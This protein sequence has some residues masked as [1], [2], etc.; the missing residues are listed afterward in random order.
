MVIPRVG[1][2]D[3]QTGFSWVT[4]IGAGQRVYRS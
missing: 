3:E 1:Q 2:G 4:P